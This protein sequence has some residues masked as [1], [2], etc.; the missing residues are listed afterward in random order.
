[1]AEGGSG[2]DDKR[3]MVAPPPYT[4]IYPGMPEDKSAKL[5]TMNGELK[6]MNGF[7]GS[8][9]IS[10]IIKAADLAARRH[11]KQR[12]KDVMQTPYVNHPI[13]TCTYPNSG[14]CHLLPFYFLLDAALFPFV[15]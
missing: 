11:R 10:Q 2:A 6:A 13:G 9:D 14:P 4:S 5:A 12:R 3:G 8:N 15:S 1:M 7:T